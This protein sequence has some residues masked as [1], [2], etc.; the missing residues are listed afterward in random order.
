MKLNDR[1]FSKGLLMAAVTLLISIAN[2]SYGQVAAPAEAPKGPRARFSETSHNFGKVG[3]GEVLRH[4]FVVTNIGTEL[5]EIT[6]VQPGCGCT[7]AGDWD[8]K[9]E[10]GKTGK[11]PIQFNPGNFSGLVTKG[12]TVTC[13][14]AVQ[15]EHHLQIQATIWRAIDVQPAFVHFMPAEGEETNETKVVKITSNLD[16]PLT[17]QKPESTNPAFKTEIKETQP[18]KQFELHVTY[19]G[20]T[21]NAA[22]NAQINVKTSSTNMPV[23]GVTAY[24]MPQPVVAAV[25]AQIQ[26]PAATT[27]HKA[28]VTIRVNGQATAKVTG[29]SV[30]AEGVT[31]QTAESQ[32]GKIYTLT[33][34][35]PAGF[36]VPAGK[37]LLMTVNTSH[38]KRPV[39][40]VP[41]FQLPAPAPA[42]V[43]APTLP[44]ASTPK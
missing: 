22:A 35:F 19:L 11:I 38:P 26:V 12:V 3:T 14:D 13:N 23:V 34:D 8:H 16:E 20:S 37:T 21:T 33:V 2:S 24:V 31:V 17:L 28:Y 15:S 42:G 39:V 43:V 27:G 9:V 29:A 41:I 32:P 10:P 4:D 30:N 6:K 40:T 5:L 7:T 36:Q 18:G 1:C 44:G 25:P